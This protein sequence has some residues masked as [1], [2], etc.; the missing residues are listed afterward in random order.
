MLTTYIDSLAKIASRI[1]N[2]NIDKCIKLIEKTINQKKTIFICGN[3]G[4][5]AIASHTLCDFVKRLYPK[6]KCKMFDLTSNN[7]LISAISNDLGSENVF[8]HQLKMFSEKKDICF[9]I[10]S[11]GNSKNIIKGIKCA[12]KKGVETI[13]I[14]GFSGGRAKKLADVVI[15]FQTKTYE[16]HEDLAQILMHYL[17]LR[18]K[19]N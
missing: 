15:H 16:H 9:F 8:S 4:S 7:I 10:S 12:K 13:A 6:K 19:K 11:S 14:L 1:E 17:Y 18:L 2:N 5:S 3:G